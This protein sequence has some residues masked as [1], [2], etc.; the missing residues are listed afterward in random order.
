MQPAMKILVFRLGAMGDILYTT[1]VLRG[2]KARY[3]DSELTYVTMKK[4]RDLVKRNL[5][6]DRVVGLPYCHPDV[7]GRLKREK[8]DLLINLQEGK[9]AAQ[10]CHAIQA[11]E[12]RG[13]DWRVD[14]IAPDAETGLLISR[15]KKDQLAQYRD[16]MSCTELFCTVADVE[17][18]S[19]TFDYTPGWF[20]SWR[21]HHFLRK[22]RLEKRKPLVALHA[23][24]RG[25]KSR[26]WN[27]KRVLEVIRALPRVHFLV[28]N[29]PSDRE[30]TRCLEGQQNATVALFNFPVQAELLRK[31]ALFVGIDSGPRNLASAMGIPILWLCGSTPPNLVPFF[32]NE[33]ALTVTHSCAPC[34]ELNCPLNKDC[35]DGISVQRVVEAIVRNLQQQ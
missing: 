9:Q 15:E 14:C 1:P 12:R 24:S 13:N 11:E 19:L 18:D 30:Q 22:H 17:P 10:T 3:P 35:L 28:L 8:F 4:W 31:C 29:H 6:V 25:C 2:L 7:L 32:E 34:F 23:Y 20:S 27:P 33:E 26:S 21:A 16:H 5:N